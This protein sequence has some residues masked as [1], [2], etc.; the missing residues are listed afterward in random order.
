MLLPREVNELFDFSNN[1]MGRLVLAVL[2]NSILLELLLE[3]KKNLPPSFA[4]TNVSI[5]VV[6]E[7]ESLNS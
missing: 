6:D 3:A 2:Q 1:A 7:R 5:R 4:K